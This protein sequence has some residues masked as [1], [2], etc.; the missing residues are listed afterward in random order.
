[1]DEKDTGSYTKGYR[2][3]YLDGYRDGSGKEC[4]CDI[5]DLP[6][7][8]LGL[9]ARAR[10]SLTRAGLERIRDVAAV[11]HT[12]I[13]YMRQLGV[14]SADEVARSLQSMG[15]RGTDWDLFLLE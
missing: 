10:N 15:I 6:L 14:K 4:P 9:S 1:M 7:E 2:V 13:R 5:P 8:Y 12:K 3:G 11:K